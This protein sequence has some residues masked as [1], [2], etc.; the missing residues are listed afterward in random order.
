MTVPLA[1]VYEQLRRD[2]ARMFK[3]DY[4][5][6]TEA[7]SVRLDRAAMLRLELEDCQTKKLAGQPFDM[8]KYVI[9]SEAL[10]RMLSPDGTGTDSDFETRFQARL[11]VEF[12]DAREAL[13][14]LVAGRA[15]C[16]D[17]HDRRD[18]SRL[19]AEIEQLRAEIERLRA[20]IVDLKKL[21]SE[22]PSPIPLP[23][24]TPATR[25][26]SPQPPLPPPSAGI[27]A[28]YLR[29]NDAGISVI[30][31]GRGFDRWSNRG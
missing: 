4:A 20:E 24:E 11:Q 15:E 25:P 21:E 27:P 22:R 19:K 12:A 23:A 1:A 16:L 26:T 28:H 29:R 8:N 14:N 6:L 3:Y 10:E 18:S 30:E 13:S 2:T 31:G 17:W 5:E 9:A 7:E